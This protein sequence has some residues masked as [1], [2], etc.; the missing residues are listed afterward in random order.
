MYAF[1]SCIWIRN[2]EKFKHAVFLNIFLV[3]IPLFWDL[4]KWTVSSWRDCF[5]AAKTVKAPALKSTTWFWR[6][7]QI[8]RGFSGSWKLSICVFPDT[9]ECSVLLHDQMICA[10]GF[11]LYI[12]LK[13][14]L[15][16][17]PNFFFFIFP[18]WIFHTSKILHR[19]WVNY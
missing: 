18:K 6:I 8:P 14:L 9:E 15:T 4:Q 11:Y 12:T 17:P 13:F 3:L 10:Q 2:K 1:L 16:S 5:T 7:I 19:R